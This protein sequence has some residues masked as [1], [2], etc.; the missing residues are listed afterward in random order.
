M[1]KNINKDVVYKAAKPKE[2][3]YMLNDGAG[4]YL[5][6]GKSGTRSWLFVYTFNK[7]R[8]KTSLGVYPGVTLEAARGK[9][10]EARENIAKGLDPIEIK[11]EIK[12]TGNFQS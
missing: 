10:V 9:A 12:K 6:V 1:A 8:K 2:K 4:L 11:S 3:D 5:L 7:K